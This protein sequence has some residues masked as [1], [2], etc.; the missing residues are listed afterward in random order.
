MLEYPTRYRI[1]FFVRYTSEMVFSE[2]LYIWRQGLAAHKILRATAVRN[3]CSELWQ[4]CKKGLQ[5][6]IVPDFDFVPSA[7]VSTGIFISEYVRLQ[8]TKT[9]LS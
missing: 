7:L 8:A 4:F 5:H 1:Y 2:T 9:R 3:D 6:V